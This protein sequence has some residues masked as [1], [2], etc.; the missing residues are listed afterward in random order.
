MMQVF[1]VKKKEKKKKKKKRKKIIFFIGWVADFNIDLTTFMT[2]YEY[3]I[4][5]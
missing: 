3:P 1:L 4:I 5:L 2:Q